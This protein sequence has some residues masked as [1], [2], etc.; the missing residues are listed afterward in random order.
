M[1]VTAAP[2]A[3]PD[4]SELL[5]P[6]TVEYYIDFRTDKTI[7]TEDICAGIEVLKS[8]E[9]FLDLDYE[10]PDRLGAINNDIYRSRVTDIEDCE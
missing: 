8:K 4:G 6:D 7:P 9:I 1:L 5:T 10:C 3:L 2:S